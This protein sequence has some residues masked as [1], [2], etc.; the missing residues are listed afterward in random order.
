MKPYKLLTAEI[1]D[2]EKGMVNNI[3]TRFIGTGDS[4]F[5]TFL[6]S[7][8]NREEVFDSDYEFVIYDK[9]PNRLMMFQDLLAWDGKIDPSVLTDVDN[10]KYDEFLAFFKHAAEKHNLQ[11]C[12]T[13]TTAWKL[14]KTLGRM[15]RRSVKDFTERWQRYKNAN[16][17]F[18]HVDIINENQKFIDMMLELKLDIKIQFVSLNINGPKDEKYSEAIDNILH[19]LWLR[20]F[21]S[22]SSMVELSDDEN[23]ITEN[24]AGKLYAQRN[25]KFCILPW[26]HIQYKPT[27]QAKLC[28]RYDNIKEQKEFESEAYLNQPENLAELF[29]QKYKVLDIQN[30]SIERTFFD[31]AYWNKAR[32]LTIENKEISGCHKCYQEEASLEDE[33]AISM[34][35]GSSVL[36]N[37]GYLHK[38]PGYEEPKIEFLEVGFGNYCNLA[39]LTCNSSLST[40]WH[41]DEVKLN[42][43]AGDNLKRLIFPKLENIKFEPN[44]QTLK[45]LRLIKF[46]GGEPMINPEFIKFIELICEKGTPEKISLEIYTNCSY[47]PSKKLLTNLT[48]F[49]DVQL[50]LS[51]DAYGLTNDYIRYGS[52]WES[53]TKQNVFDAMNFWLDCGRL[54]NNFHIMMSTTLSVLNVF[55]IPKLMT[56]WFDT[57]RQSGNK[58]V[59]RLGPKP[60]GEYDGFFKLQMAFDPSYI[61]TDL[62]PVSFYSEIINWCDQYEQEFESKYPEYDA[63]PECLRASLIKLKK[64]LSRSKGSVKNAKMLLDYLDKMDQIRGNSAEQAIPVVVSKVKEYLQAQD[65][66]I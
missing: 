22:Y 34:R 11:T 9:N 42:T 16:F 32:Q 1:I 38:R 27:G 63:M 26:M 58:V 57:Y 7:Y 40:T 39:C 52:S 66:Q 46:T 47:V 48:R 14:N 15:V 30:S 8:G 41:D 51:I 53:T 36:Y 60:R 56:W 49:K 2:H 54:H 17:K 5:S 18:V 64:A 13:D 37:D 33:V 21:K 50:N 10:A 12:E 3:V 19:S 29:P 23:K 25:S 61:S 28:C 4:I 31:S 43:L 35:L 65:K 62:L 6:R 59:I 24:F 45:T 20:S 44:E 55:E